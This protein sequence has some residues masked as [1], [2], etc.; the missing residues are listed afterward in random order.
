MA[1]SERVR[2]HEHEPGDWWAECLIYRAW[3][4][5]SNRTRRDAEQKFGRHFQNEHPSEHEGAE[6]P[7][8]RTLRI[9]GTR[10]K[11]STDHLHQNVGRR[12]LG[13]STERRICIA[14][15]AHRRRATTALVTG[16]VIDSVGYG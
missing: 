4:S 9:R 6:L 3:V 1:E 5:T 15:S 14:S 2:I 10:Q 16:P 8:L 7:M 11:A 13:L 12:A